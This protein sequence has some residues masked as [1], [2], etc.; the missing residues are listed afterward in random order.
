VNRCLLLAAVALS[1]A[2]GAEP[3]RAQRL[4]EYRVKAAVLYNLTK[5]VDW[6]TEAFPDPGAPIVVC[7]LGINPFG[8]TLNDTL[9]G[10]LVGKHPVTVKPVPEVSTGCHVLYVGSSEARQLPAILDR[11]RNRS[12]L[13]IGESA[14]FV[15]QGGMIGLI[16]DADRVRFDIN[17]GA[18]E[19]AKLKISARVLSLASS[20]LRKE[21]R[22]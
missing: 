17:V 10:H 16:T 18:A 7:V 8:P 6:P 19:Q 13:T 21:A 20:V 12:V 3:L 9:R 11:L 5:F 22:P 4:D 14:G 2:L 15:E 1:V